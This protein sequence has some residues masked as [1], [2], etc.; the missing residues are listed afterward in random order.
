MPWVLKPLEPVVAL[1]PAIV[2]GR[3]ACC[4]V[5]AV[6]SLCGVCR[7]ARFPIP[8]QEM[9]FTFFSSRTQPAP[10]MAVI[11]IG[12]R[13]RYGNIRIGGSSVIRPRALR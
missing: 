8:R 1:C 5:S 11:L 4:C 9:D 2:F 7:M 10:Q 3:A 12:S 13:Q 6:H